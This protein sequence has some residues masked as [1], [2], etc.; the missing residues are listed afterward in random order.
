MHMGDD[1]SSNLG[2][3]CIKTIPT[4]N[5]PKMVHNSEYKD[6]TIKH[7]RPEEA[8]S[9]PRPTEQPDAPTSEL[10]GRQG[11]ASFWERTEAP[12]PLPKT[13][14]QFYSPEASQSLSLN[15]WSCRF[16]VERSCRAT[17]T[18]SLL[19]WTVALRG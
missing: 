12:L 11:T 1:S 2:E 16:P 7:K 8:I 13:L 17:R 4:A 14:V 6:C 15:A 10:L 19:A 3:K 5:F 18:W 9:A